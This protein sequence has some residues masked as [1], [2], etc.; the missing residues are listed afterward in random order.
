MNN[1]PLFHTAYLNSNLDTFKFVIPGQSAGS[2]VK[3]YIAAQDS[4]GNFV[5]TKPSGGRGLN[6]PGTTPPDSMLTY[7]VVTGIAGNTD[8]YVY[9]LEQN[10]PN[11]FNPVTSIHYQLA[12][13]VQVSLKVYDVTGKEI[14]TL[15]N[16]K[17]NAGNHTIEWNASQY[18]SGV[19]FYRLT[20]GKFTEIRKMILIK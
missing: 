17:Q 13:D 15:V 7:N 12:E 19:Y 8:P 1:G 18:S 4:L 5:A 16:R 20:A 2:V 9:S 14:A 10:Y 11:P 6:P 3:Y